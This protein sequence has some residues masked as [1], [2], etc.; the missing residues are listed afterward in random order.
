LPTSGSVLFFE[1]G[2]RV[3]S[4]ER[5]AGSMRLRRDFRGTAVI[6]GDIARKIELNIR[7]LTPP[8]LYYDLEAIRR[9]PADM[10]RKADLI[11]PTH[12]WDVLARGT[13]G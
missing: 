6:V 9:A 4:H 7:R 3:V 13:I 11:L 10:A 2:I 5:R 1:L 8:G 12:D